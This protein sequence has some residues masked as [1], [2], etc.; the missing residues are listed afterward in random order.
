M[1]ASSPQM[2]DVAAHYQENRETMW[3]HAKRQLFLRGRP[4]SEAKDIVSRTMLSL[5]EHPPAA[6]VNNWEALLVRAVTNKV[7][8]Y[9][10]SAEVAHR[11]PAE[12]D[13]NIPDLG[14]SATIER[15]ESFDLAHRISNYFPLLNSQQME[16]LRQ[17][18]LL[19]LPRAEVANSMR[20]SG[21]RVTQLVK[22]A[23]DILKAA[24]AQEG[25]FDA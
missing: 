3:R 7:L 24:I 22:E 4:A 1:T 25:V 18:V 15:I 13:D 20:L 14:S 2:P 11:S 21:P 23:V 9:T 16:A 6:P 8:D 12:L 5:L 19:D 17:R 10:K